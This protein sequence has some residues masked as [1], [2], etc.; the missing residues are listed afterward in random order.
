MTEMAEMLAFTA[1][2]GIKPTIE[3][4]PMTEASRAL[5]HT[6]QGKAPTFLSPR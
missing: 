6:R 1:R 4:L 2:H 5:E 3:T